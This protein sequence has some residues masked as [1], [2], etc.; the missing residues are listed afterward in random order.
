MVG[1]GDAFPLETSDGE[2]PDGDAAAAADALTS[3]LPLRFRMETS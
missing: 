1:A 2:S 3:V